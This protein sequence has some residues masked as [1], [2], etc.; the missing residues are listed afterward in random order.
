MVA[1]LPFVIIASL[2][3]PKAV[4]TVSMDGV[5]VAAPSAMTTTNH[6]VGAQPALPK[7]DLD[8]VPTNDCPLTACY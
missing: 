7:V 8:G 3:H 4:A 2:K 6:L 5:V 1:G